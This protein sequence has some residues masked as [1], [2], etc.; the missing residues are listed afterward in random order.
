VL[1]GVELVQHVADVAAA[2]GA[3]GQG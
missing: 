3:L 1:L 2:I